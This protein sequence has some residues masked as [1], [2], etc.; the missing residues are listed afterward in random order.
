MNTWNSVLISLLFASLIACGSNSK[1]ENTTP[2]QDTVAAP[3]PEPEPEPEV[4]PEPEPEPE[5]E[6]APVA[7]LQEIIYFEFDSSTLS[8]SARANL[9]ENAEWLREDESRTLRIE[10]HT[11]S[12]GTEEY[13]LGLGQRRAQAAK[14]YLVR[15][16]IPANRIRIITYG[17]TRPASDEDAENRRSVFLAT[18]Q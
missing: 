18:R 13:N 1:P 8:D 10:G 14:D 15:L 12:V 11:D 17:E 4:Q 9:E 2:T 16:G 5:P 3:E 6:P 7:S